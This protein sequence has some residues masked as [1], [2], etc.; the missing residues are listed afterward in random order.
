MPSVLGQATGPVVKCAGGVQ[1]IYVGGYNDHT[2]GAWAA[3]PMKAEFDKR[4]IKVLPPVPIQVQYAALEG[5]PNTPD[6]KKVVDEGRRDLVDRLKFLSKSRPK[7]VCFSLIGYSTGVLA[8]E[9]ALDGGDDDVPA[10]VG[11][12]I[13]SIGLFSD[14]WRWP[15]VTNYQISDAYKGR[16]KYYCNDHDPF[17]NVVRVG[18]HTEEQWEKCKKT[19]DPGDCFTPEH[20]TPA[21]GTKARAE[22][23]RAALLA[24]RA[25]GASH[26][27]VPGDTLWDLAV[28]AYG[29]GAK[30]QAIYAANRDAIEQA[31]R[32]HGYASSDGGNLIFPGS[33]LVIPS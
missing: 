15:G 4:G 16:Y 32:E 29:D 21:Y 13:V 17:C 11:N 1:I 3:L 7:D 19:R 18:T 26:A 14:P 28:K 12:Q 10:D 9:T 5:W 2:G 27:V 22:G 33:S 25:R 8:I 24:A 31:A 6:K 30:W 23:A 20:L